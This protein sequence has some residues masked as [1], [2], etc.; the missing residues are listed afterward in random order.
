MKVVLTP[1][2]APSCPGVG[3]IN[4]HSRVSLAPVLLTECRSVADESFLAFSIR[5]DVVEAV[6]VV[7]DGLVLSCELVAFKRNVRGALHLFNGRGHLEV[8]R[9]DN[10]ADKRHEGEVAT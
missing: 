9:S 3:A 4:T 1:T 8:V 6:V 10:G 7:E 2:S 5:G